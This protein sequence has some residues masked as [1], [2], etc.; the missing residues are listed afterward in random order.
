MN[1]KTTIPITE[2]R[3]RIFEIAEEVQK[4]GLYYIFTEKGKPKAVMMSAEE[5]ESWQETIDVLWEFPDLSKD[6]R[7]AEKDY[8]KG[9]YIT[10]DELIAK[11]SHVIKDKKHAIS[12]RSAKRGAKGAKED[13]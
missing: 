11:E 6:T 13:R 1:T 3:K 8:K 10:L 4:P 5:F 2:A 7:E 9:N 12:S